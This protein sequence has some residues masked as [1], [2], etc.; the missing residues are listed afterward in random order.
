MFENLTFFPET[1][2][3]IAAQVDW[4]YFFMWTLTIFF[5]VLIAGL[6]LGFIIKFRKQPGNEEPQPMNPQTWIEIV[7]TVIPL[8]IVLVIFFW[9]AYLYLQYVRIPEDT[10]NIYGTGK[11]W[12]WKFQHP[13]GQREINVL[14]VPVNTPVK[15]TLG[16]EDVIHSFYV[17]DFRVKADVVPGTYR[18]TW[19]EATK[20]GRFRLFCAEYCG[21]QHAGMIG[22]VVVMSK[23]DYQEWISGEVVQGSLAEQGKALFEKFRCHTCHASEGQGIGPNLAGIYGR[24]EQLTNGRMIEVNDAYLY[25]SIV[26]PQDKVTLGYQPIMPSFKDQISEEEIVKIIEYIKSLS[27]QEKPTKPVQPSEPTQIESETQTSDQGV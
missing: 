24:K 9:S 20:T 18:E 15:V 2:S 5:S 27:Q 16:S 14:H 17:P 4:F 25:E 3:T 11:Q 13:T 23:Q 26:N 1:A 22:E 12:M 21:M 7:W 19:F 8:G 10:L 6:I